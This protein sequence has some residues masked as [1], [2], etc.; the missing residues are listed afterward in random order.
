MVF[1]RFK[2]ALIWAITLMI[3]FVAQPVWTPPSLGAS[4]ANTLEQKRKSTQKELQRIRQIKKQI[5]LKER[6]V[7]SNIVENQKRLDTSRESMESQQALLEGTRSQLKK[8][9]ADLDVALAEQQRFADKVGKRLRGLYMGERLGFLQM[10]LEAGDL[11]TLL[12][13][14]Y[15]KKRILQQDKS[16]YQTYIEKTQILEGKKD[17]LVE[18]KSRLA[19]TIGKIHAYQS[20]LQ[21]S[22]V[23][24]KIL[25]GKLKTSRE[26]YDMAEN[27]LEQE[28]YRI[29]RQ[30]MSLTNQGGV[31]I[32]STGRFMR[33][34]LAAIS[35]SFGY[36]FH[37]IFHTKRFHSGT[38]FGAAYGSAIRAADGGKVI[39]AGWQGGYGKTVIIN[40]GAQGGQNISTL[41]GHMSGLAVGNGQQVGK[42]QVIGYVGS[43]GYST[44]PHLHFEVR[45]NGRPVNPLGYLK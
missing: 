39:Q 21:E 27:Q 45:L 3:L 29:E 9:E 1:S 42:G 38:D 16:L 24:D 5:L 35:S 26:A 19:L 18:Q 37:P 22:M 4:S 30:I 13:R 44:G 28:S 23:L 2:P 10:F 14:M 36:R 43:T 31:V 15:Y 34:V 32:G 33:P 25:V 40:H 6:F 12:D 7:T 20:Q 11:S 17:E 41:Y 8:L